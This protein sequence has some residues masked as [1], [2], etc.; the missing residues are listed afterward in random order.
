MLQRLPLL[1]K[2]FELL[3]VAAFPSDRFTQ[4]VFDKGRGNA[5]SMAVITTSTFSTTRSVETTLQVGG[6]AVIER[7][8]LA[9]FSTEGLQDRFVPIFIDAQGGQ[10][11]GVRLNNIA[12]PAIVKASLVVGFENPYDTEIN[13][14]RMLSTIGRS[15]LKRWNDGVI[16]IPAASPSVTRNY[17]IPSNRGECIGIGVVGYSPN[18]QV[19][20]IASL[21]LISINGTNIFENVPLNEF[22]NTGNRDNLYPC[23]IPDG[24]TVKIEIEAAALILLMYLDVTFYFDAEKNQAEC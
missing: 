14:M 23:S 15:R 12:D 22:A 5:I 8:S 17:I 21:V 16:N 7:S 3:R 9:Y 6:V 11:F 19:S 2:G 18:P 13:R 10:T 24:S 4:G 1:K 20:A